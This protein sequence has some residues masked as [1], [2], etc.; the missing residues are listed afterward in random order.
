MYIEDLICKLNQ[1]CKVN[2]YDVNL[3]PSLVN[4]TLFGIGFTEKQSILA[5]RILKRYSVNLSQS[6]GVDISPF[7]ENPAFKYRLRKINNLKKISVVDY[8]Q[9]GRA[10]KVEFPFDQIKIDEIRKNR[11]KLGI[12]QWDIEH[13]AWMFSLNEKNIQFLANFV[14]NNGFDYDTEFKDYLDQVK[15]IIASMEKYVPMLAIENNEPKYLNI[16]QFVPKLESKEVI[17]ALFEAKKA[18]IFTWDDSISNYVDQQGLNSV[19][20]E[21][22]I[23]DGTKNL[24]IDSTQT[25]I[26][27]LSEIVKFTSPTLFIIPGGSE[28]DKTKM[29]NNFLTKLGYANNEMS[30]MFRLPSSQGRDFNEFVKSCGLNNPISEKTK[31][32][33]VSIKLPKPVI[34]SKL[35]FGSVISLGQTNV[36]YTIRDFFKN[37]T[38]LIYY[39]ESNKQREFNFA[40]L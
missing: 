37:R 33:F 20:R 22:L 26:D 2:R 9:W 7:L 17:S 38:N 13:K 3:V 12:C 27:C 8:A 19:T 35:K 28:L 1:T 24:E 34:K 21:F 39:C 30:V 11:E 14:E 40:V 29:V 36:H 15:E 4:Q 25:P 10:I 32:V 5:I 31:F 23:N 6:L 16:S 18:G